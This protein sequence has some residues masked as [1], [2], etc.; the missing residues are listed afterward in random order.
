MEEVAQKDDGLG[1]KGLQSLI[2]GHKIFFIAC[3]GAA[4]TN[5]LKWE[6][7]PKWTSLMSKIDFSFQ[8]SAP[9]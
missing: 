8:K 3:W 9:E 1:K 2:H 5:F 4:A 6:T 7:F